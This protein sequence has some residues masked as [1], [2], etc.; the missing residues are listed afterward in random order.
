M[1]GFLDISTD[2]TRF[3]TILQIKVLF[4]EMFVFLGKP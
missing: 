3:T 4:K 2:I 1:N